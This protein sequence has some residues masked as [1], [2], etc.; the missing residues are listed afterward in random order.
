VPV[1]DPVHNAT[2]WVHVPVL[3]PNTPSYGGTSL[4]HPLKPSAY[5]GD[6]R[7]WY[8]Q[9]SIHNPMLDE[10]GRL[11]MTSRIRPATSEPAYCQ[12]GS[13][14]PSAQQFPLKTSGRQASM[15]DPKTHLFLLANLCFN[16]HHL[17]FAH[18]ANDTLWFSAGGGNSNVVGWLNTKEFVRT[19]DAEHAQGWTPLLLDVPGTGKRTATWTEPGQPIDPTKDA[20]ILGDFYGL[21]VSPVDESIWGS[22]LGY[23]GKI[24]RIVPGSD[25][26]RTA[27][28]EVY[29]L[30]A[31]DPTV[32][33]RGYSPRGLD[34]D[35][36]GVVWVPLGSGH[37]GSFDRRKCRGPLSGP[38]ATGK[39]CPEGWTLYPF[40]GPQFQGLTESGSAEAS[41]YTWVDRFDTLGL[42]KN[43]PVATGNLGESVM[44]LVNGRF[45]VMRV[46]YPMGF[47]AKNVDGRIDDA[48]AGWR[49]RGVWS[50]YGSRAPFHMETG[51]GQKP[52]VLHFQ[53]R[54]NPLAD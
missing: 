3:D 53:I 8:S 7:I 37:L 31:E 5:W 27:L 12:A 38:T 39:Q 43:V 51:K 30:P 40:P 36:N 35:G 29:E 54:P 33:V 32:A 46:P 4:E 41:Y 45:V 26:A 10:Y 22:V 50:T 48:R 2:D 11:W 47:Y 20:R 17:Y 49:G 13:S 16:T 23:P 19:G 6:E 52:I 1:L 9:D 24:V 14:L 28:S 34:I 18:D 21:G 25:P 15:Y 44:A 42:G